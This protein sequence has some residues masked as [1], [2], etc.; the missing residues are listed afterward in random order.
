MGG[1]TPLQR[2]VVS[3]LP[4]LL[5]AITLALSLHSRLSSKLDECVIYREHERPPPVYIPM[6]DSALHN[7]SVFAIWAGMLTLLALPERRAR[8]LYALLY[9]ALWFHVTYVLLCALKAPLD[10]FNCA[11]RHRLYPNGV[12][13]HYCYF[14]F[15]TLCAPILARA[16]LRANPTQQPAFIIAPAMLFFVLFAVGAPATLYR[17]WAHGYHSARQILL[18][19]ALG[20]ASHAAVERFFL[21]RLDDMAPPFTDVLELVVLGAGSC[22][23][24]L[25]YHLLWPL[26]TAGPALTKGHYQFHIGVWVALLA[27]AGVYRLLLA[28]S[29]DRLKVAVA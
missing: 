18:G 4:L 3:V 25:F 11:G 7:Y 27:A 14:L 17:T 21:S 13:G 20:L 16:R 23:S 10:D 15:V 19:S 28:A 9:T 29:T 24:F 6:A 26:S 8:G 1:Y 2:R 12:S 22:T 5:L